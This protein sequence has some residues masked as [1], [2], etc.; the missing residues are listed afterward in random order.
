MLSCRGWVVAKRHLARIS[1]LR[2]L[3]KIVCVVVFKIFGGCLK[4]FPLPDRSLRWKAPLPDRPK[5]SLFVFS[6]AK[7]P[8]L[9][10]FS[11]NFSGV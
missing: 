6:A 10:V 1:V 2:V 9:G 11:L 4:I 7:S 5:I 8:S 3:A